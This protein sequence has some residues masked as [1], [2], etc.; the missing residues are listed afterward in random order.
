MDQLHSKRLEILSLLARR[1]GTASRMPSIR[2]IAE[3]VGLKSSQ[4]VYHHLNRLEA[5]GYL[6]RLDDRPRTPKL[7]EK[8]W[9]A[10]LDGDTPLLGR[11]AAG[12]GLEAVAAGDEA[13]SLAAELLLP[14]P[15]RRRYLL[16]VVGQSMTGAR[17]EDGDLLV[18]EEDENPPNGTV[19]VALLGNGEEVTVKRLYREGREI[20]LKPQNGGHEDIVLLGEDV[21][22]QGRVVYVIHPPAR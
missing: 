22:I 14:N 1:E 16:R 12:R 18:I 10:V 8:G 6:E 9:R 13:Y 4:T 15:G 5:S 19:V 3:A 11:I 21:E 2:E 7:T 20:R 17:I